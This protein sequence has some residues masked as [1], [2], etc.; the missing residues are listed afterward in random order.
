MTGLNYKIQEMA[1][2]IRE[3]R[4]IENFTIAEMAMKTGVTEQE[5]IDCEL[6]RSD[7]N[8]AFLYRCA[9][10]FGVDVGD[11]IE[12]SSPN[13]NSFTV[14]RRGE[15]QRIEEAH[16]M[17]YYNMAASFRNRI[18]EPLY[19]Q[20]AYSAEAEK[21]DIKLTTHEG[22][23]CD[24]VIE[25]QLKVQVGEHISVLNPGDSIYY[26]SGTPHGMIAVGGQDCLFYAIVLNPTGAPIPELTPEKAVPG[27]ALQ[28]FP[29]ENGRTRVWHRYAD[30]EKDENGTPVKIAFKNTEKFNFAFDVIDAIADEV[31]NKLA[32][33]HLDKDKNEHRF[34]FNDLKR[35]SN[36]CANYF[37][38]LGIKKGDRVLLVLK[39]HY[40]FWFSI[41]A[42]EKIGA[43]GIPAVAQLQEHD[44]EYRFNAAGIKAIICTADGDTAH[45]ADLAAKNAPSLELKLIVNGTREGWHTFDEEYQMYSTHFHRTDDTPCGDDLMLM[46]FTSGT[47][48]YP[49]IAAHSYKHPLGHLHT[50]KYWHCVNPNGL[51]LTISDTGWAKAGWGK[52]YGQWL[53]EAAI[54][55]YD[56]DRFDAADILPLFA[57]YHITTFCAPPTM[58]RML[59]KQ[60]LSKYDLSSVTH[61]SSA[62]EALN[63]EVFRQIEKQT[64]LQVMEG[65]G[66]TESTMIIGNLAGADHKLGSMGKVAPIYKVALLDPEGKEV[67]VGTSGEICVDISNGIPIGLFRE[68]YRDEEKTKEVMHDGWYHTGDV[69]WCDEDGF[70]WY[71]GRA[72]DV[73]K[74]SGYRIG[75]FEIESVI[76]EL[77]YVLECG[78]SAAPDEVRGQVVKASIVLT[79]GTEPTEELKKE[80]QNY[81]KQHTAPYKYPRIVVFR[82]ELPK[83]VSGKIQRAL[84]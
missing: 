12:G 23:E 45:Q 55:V 78:V 3:L 57:K 31:P 6:G 44:F 25:G 74:S 73:I 7:L 9:L 84:L 24:I 2:R 56:F 43:I 32:M 16:D 69:A 4:E 81:V 53:C 50:A 67:P 60:D 62:G 17:I 52:I 79:K 28:E 20:A 21:E 61:A 5:Y 66:Q 71:V 22:Q 36:R 70:Y 68:Y 59:I 47:T 18:A 26:D 40:Q 8:F 38:S 65:F 82:D 48:G 75:P 42:L 46:Y 83:T 11:I 10:A 49:K 34:T 15:G 19:V 64:G 80:I 29:A 39:R 41:L 54:F 14:T 33:L 72:D 63:P 13:L 35:A 37:K 58:W 51:H 77:P 30:V 76:M 1:H 27:T